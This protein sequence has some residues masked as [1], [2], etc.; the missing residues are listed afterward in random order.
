MMQLNVKL[1]HL[2]YLI[3]HSVIMLIQVHI[4]FYFD[5]V[6]L[7]DVVI[8]QWHVYQIEHKIL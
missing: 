5:S 3:C 8:N 7:F 2:I 1:V 4:F 6:L